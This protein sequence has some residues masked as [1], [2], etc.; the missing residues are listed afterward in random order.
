LVAANRE[1]IVISRDD[2]AVGTVHVHFPRT[3]Y[4]AFPG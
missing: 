3:G 2:P 1:R 4:F